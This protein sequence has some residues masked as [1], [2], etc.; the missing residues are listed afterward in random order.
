MAS[1]GHGIRSSLAEIGI[2]VRS[3]CQSAMFGIKVLAI[4]FG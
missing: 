3:D 1:L 4:K 2:N